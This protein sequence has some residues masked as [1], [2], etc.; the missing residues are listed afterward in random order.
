MEPRLAGDEGGPQHPV[1]TDAVQPRDGGIG[2]ALSIRKR[3]EVWHARGTVRVGK[4]SIEVREFSTGSRSRTGALYVAAA[5]EARIRQ[6]HLEGSAG[7]A[8]RLTLGDCFAVYL[9]RPGG[10]QPYDVARVA[11]LNEAIG[12]RKLAD[13]PA[14][15]QE[16]LKH[17]PRQSAG[18]VQRW[19]TILAAA[20]RM[21]CEAHGLP[22]PKLPAV[23]QSREVR[24]VYLSPVERERLLAAY[25]PHAS[26]PV[27]LLAYQGMRT[28]E[29]LRL[30]WRAVDWA[31]NALHMRAD[32]TKTGRG[33]TVPM[34]E[35]VRA[36][37]AELWENAGCPHAG[38][39]FLS[40][41][42]QPYQDTRGI[43]G[44]PLKKQ[45]ALACRKAGVVGFRVHDWRHDFAAR[46]VMSGMDLY[47]LMRIG[48][49]TSL[50]MVER[51]S[52]ISA[53]HAREA[54]GR[55]A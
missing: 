50:R 17:H 11:Q 25:P 12:D 9:S 2:V 5:E 1:H 21:G 45:H 41:R 33:R 43:G 38:P 51:Y 28:Q 19:R 42:R 8:R 35:R 13:V 18:T 20:L 54:M 24:V 48:G 6:E 39:V 36:M 23:K 3:G 15:W 55:V 49:W 44:N 29:A 52:S 16:W 37:L 10:L 34:H 27:L 31:R 26:R 47:T 22:A 53:E 4:E 32:M 40:S 7:R 14:A 46:C 30:D